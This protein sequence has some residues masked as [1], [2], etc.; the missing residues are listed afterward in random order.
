MSIE[1]NIKG[2]MIMEK[3]RK[4]NLLLNIGRLEKGDPT[5]TDGDA[6][7][8][9]YPLIIELG[10]MEG[11][12]KVK[13]IEEEKK[14]TLSRDWTPEAS[15]QIVFYNTELKIEKNKQFDPKVA[16]FLSFLEESRRTRTIAFDLI[17]QIKKTDDVKA[18][19]LPMKMLG[20][21]DSLNFRGKLL[22][23]KVVDQASKKPL[24]VASK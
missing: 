17:K 23:A 8:I 3:G 5:N 18:S 16:E 15:E 2:D 13:I 19:I 1:L 7:A 24:P 14:K 11:K 22:A 20:V 10:L 6:F 21:S 4:D 9:K 12:S